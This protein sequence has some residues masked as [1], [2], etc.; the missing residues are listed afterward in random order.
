[1]TGPHEV[2]LSA[3]D[4]AAGEKYAGP[5]DPG[6][7]EDYAGEPVP[8]PWDEDAEGVTSSASPSG[9]DAGPPSPDESS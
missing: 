4:R 9:S 3:E 7:P 5:H 2:P 8:D 1:M 6:R